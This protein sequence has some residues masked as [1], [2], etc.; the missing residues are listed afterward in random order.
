MKYAIINAD[1]VV[2]SLVI[3][4]ALNG[5]PTAPRLHTVVEMPDDAQ[6]RIGWTY[7]P[8]SNTFAPQ[9]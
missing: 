2:V 8:E 5:Y 7:N 6:I 4:P 3:W 1:N 9:Q